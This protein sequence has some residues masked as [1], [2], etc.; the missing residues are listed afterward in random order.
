[1]LMNLKQ[2]RQW[3]IVAFLAFI[4][5]DISVLA[6]AGNIASGLGPII[7]NY[8]PL[9]VTSSGSYYDV[10]ATPT[11]PALPGG[12]QLSLGT[13]FYDNQEYPGVEVFNSPPFPVTTAGVPCGLNQSAVVISN[14]AVAY[15]GKVVTATVTRTTWGVDI[16]AETKITYTPQTFSAMVSPWVGT[17]WSA[18]TGHPNN[19]YDFIQP[20][21]SGIQR[22][23]GA[24]GSLCYVVDGGA[25]GPNEDTNLQTN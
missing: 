24:D 6:V 4:I 25:G 20:D 15:N 17:P 5:T 8:E 10:S 12:S 2:K 13:Q 9:K 3:T 16:G 7:T 14:K 23:Q 21:S 18:S 19:W 11:G 22:F 1:M